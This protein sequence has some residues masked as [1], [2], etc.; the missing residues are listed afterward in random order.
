MELRNRIDQSLKDALRSGDEVRKRTIRLILSAVKLA[1]VEK[2]QSLDNDAL[3]AVIQ[4]EI[5]IRKES[6]DGAQQA[7]RQDLLDETNKEIKVLEQFLPMQLSDSELRELVS[8]AIAETGAVSPADTGKVMKI[9][10]P[11]VKGRATG[12]RIS[13]IIR[14]ILESSG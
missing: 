5:K 3:L 7:G 10:M 11:K 2:G 13:Q 9:V 8:M 14:E 1:E 4:K 12:D 6:I